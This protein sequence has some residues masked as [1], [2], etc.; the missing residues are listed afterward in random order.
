[1]L[2]MQN[3]KQPADDGVIN[4]LDTMQKDLLD[5]LRVHVN[6]T[7]KVDEEKS[8]EH[9]NNYH[10]EDG[11][12][13]EV[14]IGSHGSIV[15][16]LSASPSQAAG[17]CSGNIVIE[18]I[19]QDEKFKLIRCVS[20]RGGTGT[21]NR[22]SSSSPVSQISCDVE[23]TTIND[24][25]TKSVGSIDHHQYG[26]D[27]NNE[28]ESGLKAVQEEEI[29]S[30]V[31]IV[32]K[33]VPGSVA[34]SSIGS[35]KKKNDKTGTLSLTSKSN[36]ASRNSLVASSVSMASQELNA[37]L[38]CSASFSSASVPLDTFACDAQTQDSSDNEHSLITSSLHSVLTSDHH[39]DD[40]CRTNTPTTIA[41]S[42]I[43]ILGCD[44]SNSINLSCDEE[45]NVL[46][47]YECC[48]EEY[49]D[50]ASYNTTDEEEETLGTLESMQRLYDSQVTSS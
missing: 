7:I 39:H 42:V 27:E 26:H 46:K 36:T 9:I 21:D 35:E 23:S 25:T 20:T 45:K 4:E 6:H 30:K 47:H 15:A 48:A 3:E 43:N 19:S 41:Q 38:R 33:E 17:T 1:M 22:Q 12:K 34:S 24:S 8:S 5:G 28:E 13:E 40:P 37:Q 50:Y 18:E 44:P 31:L 16:S 32:T 29:S 10:Y 2:Y 14:D 11:K 49:D